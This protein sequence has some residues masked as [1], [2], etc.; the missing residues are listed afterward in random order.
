MKTIE[1]ITLKAAHAELT[2]GEKTAGYVKLADLKALCL[3][4][5]KPKQGWHFTGNWNKSVK[6]HYA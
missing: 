6:P 4:D 5:R 3:P 2:K 1:I